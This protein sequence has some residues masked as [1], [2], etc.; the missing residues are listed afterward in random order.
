MNSEIHT[1]RAITLE[2]SQNFSLNPQPSWSACSVA[3]ILSQMK[4]RLGFIRIRTYTSVNHDILPL[5]PQQRTWSSVYD[6]RSVQIA[7]LQVS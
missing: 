2:S 3:K 5:D 6:V 7:H 4:L 1:F